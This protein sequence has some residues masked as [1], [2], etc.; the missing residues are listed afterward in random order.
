MPLLTVEG[1]ACARNHQLLFKDVELD[2][3]P[4]HVVQIVGANGS[5]KTTLLKSL[6]G[7]HAPLKGDLHWGI[8]FQLIEHD[9]GLNESLTVL[10]NIKYYSL[11]RCLLNVDY[12]Y[13][14][15]HFRLTDL[16][17]RFVAELSRGQQ[18]R[19]ALS[20]LQISPSVWLLDEPFTSLDQESC[21]FVNA[22]FSQQVNKGGAI[23]FTSHREIEIN[24][25][26]ILKI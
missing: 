10:E 25:S 18:Q 11:L 26:S 4:G 13:L 8:S 16:Q 9:L 17:H 6:A 24:E 19:L 12:E 21:L 22:L 15:G 14:L 1:L 2:L 23:V 3:R 7:V 5:G 20:R